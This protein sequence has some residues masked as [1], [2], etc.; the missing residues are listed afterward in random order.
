MPDERPDVEVESRPGADFIS[1]T[2][3]HDTSA[4]RAYGQGLRATL[5]IAKGDRE[6]EAIAAAFGSSFR[7]S[8]E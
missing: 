4:I 8:H 1:R 6:R 3:R 7:A 2:E 5:L